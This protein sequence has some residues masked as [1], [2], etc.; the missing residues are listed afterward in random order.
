MVTFY[1]ETHRERFNDYMSRG[2]F[3]YRDKM[4]TAFIYVIS[5]DLLKN[6]LP[7]IYDLENGISLATDDKIAAL[8]SSEQQLIRLASNIYGLGLSNIPTLASMLSNFDTKSLHVLKGVIEIFIDHSEGIGAAFKEEDTKAVSR[9][10]GVE[11]GIKVM[12]FIHNM[13]VRERLVSEGHTAGSVEL[14]NVTQSINNY[15]G[16]VLE[17]DEDGNEYIEPLK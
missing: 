14:E 9:R 16:S 17:I 3:D 8:S 10:Q 13:N 12:D 2:N 4:S 7:Y 1:T 6:K 5:C 11:D 15:I